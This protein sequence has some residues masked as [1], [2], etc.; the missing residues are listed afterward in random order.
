[1]KYW[2]IKIVPKSLNYLP[3]YND[4]DLKV[5]NSKKPS[6]NFDI[7]MNFNTRERKRERESLVEAYK[8]Q[9]EGIVSNLSLSKSIFYINSKLNF[10][11]SSNKDKFKRMM[12]FPLQISIMPWSHWTG[13]MFN[14]GLNDIQTFGT[15][16]RYDCE[17]WNVWTHKIVFKF[18]NFF[19]THLIYFPFLY[20]D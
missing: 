14:L 2:S 8:S 1:M 19:Q 18:N 5:N 20:K 6:N 13:F 12:E 11:S 16:H 15:F 3:K 10:P 4:F 7:S 9:I 17:K